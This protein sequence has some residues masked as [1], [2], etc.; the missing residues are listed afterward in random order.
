M[1]TLTQGSRGQ[2][3]LDVQCALAE[4]DLY[5]GDFDGCFGPHM[6]A[7]VIAFQQQQ[8]LPANGIVDDATAAA[9]HMEDTAPVTCQV[10]GITAELVAPMFPNTP[11]ENIEANLPCVLNALSDA[12]LCDKQMVLMALATIRAETGDFLPI[13]EFQSHFNTSPGGRPFDLYD[14]RTDLGNQGPPDGANFR[15]RGFIQLTGRNNFQIHSAA[16]GLSDQLLSSPTLANE[17]ETAAKLLASFLKAHEK[18]IR[19]ALATNNL[20]EARRLVNG[21]SNGLEEFENAFNTG[22]NL[23]PD[24]PTG[25]QSA[26]A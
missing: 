13:S 11:I 8:G 21:G 26:N 10:Q 14:H 16:I 18:Q 25:T 3:V 6:Q 1:R 5:S 23:I 7:A 12:G 4:A 24:L 19:D 22:L 17:P 20:T 15:G 2:D 9:L